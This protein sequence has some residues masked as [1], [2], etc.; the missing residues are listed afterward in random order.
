MAQD[1]I[2][3][4]FGS[5]TVIGSA[6]STQTRK[7]QIRLLCRCACG[8]EKVVQ[9][10]N[11]V[12]GKSTSCGCLRV[13]AMVERVR[14]H[15]KYKTRTYRIWGAMKTRATNEKIPC[16]KHYSIRGIKCCQRWM[17]SFEAFLSDM[18]EAP[19]GM[20]LDRIDVNGDY[21]PENCRW[22]TW[23]EQHSNRTDTV[24]VCY[25]GQMMPVAEAERL[26]GL[27]VNM[28]RGRIRLGWPEGKWF[29]PPM[30]KGNH[31]NRQLET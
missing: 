12:S 15:G 19:E 11:L 29:D 16:A 14:T 27:P 4:V 20:T 1:Y 26:A 2:G 18:G 3:A 21:C 31:L 30:G 17:D 28:V 25:Q 10:G 9:K 24:L 6:P 22:A 8:V 13:A 23:K 5:W 7:P